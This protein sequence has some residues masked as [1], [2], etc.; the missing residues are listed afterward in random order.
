MKLFSPTQNAALLDQLASSAFETDW[1]T[2]SV[3]AGSSGYDPGSYA[4]GSVWAVGTSSL[5]EAFWFE[6]RPATAL[7]LWRALLPWSQLD[8]PGHMHE[9]LAGDLYRPQ[10]ESVPEQTWSSAGFLHATVQGLLGLT[11]DGLDR[12][13]TFAPHLPAEWSGLSV[14]NIRVGNASVGLVLHRTAQG[15]TLSID[16]GG[17]DLRLVFAPELPLGAHLGAAKLADKPIPAALESHPQ[18]TDARVVFTAPHGKSELRIGYDGG[19]SVIAVPPMPKLGEASSGVHIIGIKLAGNVLT[20]DADVRADRASHL[21]VQSTWHV[22]SVVGAD[23]VG[24]GN[25]MVEL[26]IGNVGD[27]AVAGPYHH[28]AVKVQFKP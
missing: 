27:P 19:V 18:E 17:N 22:A 11:V 26:T 25:D 15:L 20:I 9:V 6:N 28:V 3:G 7:G 16:N 2:R 1:G 5:A 12:R 13:I 24:M 14:E 10:G 23:W 4:K 8:S 21:R